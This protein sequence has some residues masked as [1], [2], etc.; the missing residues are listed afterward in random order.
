MVQSLVGDVAGA[1]PYVSA[2]VLRAGPTPPSAHQ[3]ESSHNWYLALLVR[4]R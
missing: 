4:P 1:Y 3:A 2:Q